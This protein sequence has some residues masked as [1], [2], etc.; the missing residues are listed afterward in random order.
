[1]VK[2]ISK[3][4]LVKCMKTNL[5]MN[6]PK[7]TKETLEKS[8][9][10]SKNDRCKYS[11]N[12]EQIKKSAKHVKLQNEKG[13][14]RELAKLRL[15]SLQMDN[16]ELFTT[17][18]ATEDMLE[19][20]VSLVKL[21]LLNLVTHLVFANLAKTNQLLH[22]TQSAVSTQQFALMSVLL[23]LIPSK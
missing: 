13:K 21:E 10:M 12:L 14:R 11:V 17:V 2:S 4:V 3:E 16:R 9:P 22:F 18:N 5:S 8:T 6:T 7:R 15:L 20:S 23:V 1:M 19:H